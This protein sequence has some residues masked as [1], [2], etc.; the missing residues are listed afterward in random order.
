MRGLRST[1]ALVVVLVGLGGLHLLR[2][3]EDARP[4]TRR[5]S[6]KGLRR[7]EADKI[8]E[9]KVKSDNGDVTHAQ[10]GERRLA[11]RRAGR[12][13]RPTSPKCRASPTRSAARDR[14]GRSTRT[15]PTS[16]TTAWRRRASRSIS[17]RP[18]TRTTAGCSIGDK[19]PTGGDLFAKRNDEK[20]VFLIPAS[21]E[22]TLNRSTFD[23]RDKTVLKFDREKVDGIERRR[24]AARRWRSPRTATDWKIT[25]PLQARAD[26]GSGRRAGR[27]AADDRHEVDRRRTTPTPADLK[28]Y[29][30]DKPA[31]TV[32]LKLG[33]ARATLA[34][35][36]KAA[37][38][39]VY[40]RDASKPVVVT[41]DSALA[42]D[43]KKGA[44]DYRRKDIF[45]FRPFNATR[46]EITRNG[47]T[48]VFE[49]VK[50][51]RQAPRTSGGASARPPPT[52]TRT[53]SIRCSP[54]VEH[55][56]RL[57]RRHDR[58]DRP[59]QAGDDGGREVRRWQE[60]RTGDVRQGRQRRLRRA[61]RRAR[62]R[63]GGRD[64]LHRS[65]QNPR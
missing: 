23:L 20:K 13:P 38:D 25:Q 7:L 14:P 34:V 26:F 24:A 19:S 52:S 4:T 2:H 12:R 27:P 45:E 5:R 1:I 54:A 51:R 16:R 30:L 10:E 58:E 37:D 61:S 62:R 35:G 43:L 31:A 29:G 57:V 11:G 41:V 28:K 39:T 18:A 32:N 46:I 6:R 36:G 17:R 50:G 8:E 42:D 60:G 59:R 44:D 56:R 53:R 64:G 3:L 33:S 65:E 49:R 15:R 48:V 63:K 55:P 9:I 21:Q 47:Q 40:A 22:S